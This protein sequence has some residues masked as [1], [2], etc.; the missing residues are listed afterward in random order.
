MTTIINED[1]VELEELVRAF[2]FYFGVCKNLI[3]EFNK[4]LTRS[5]TKEYRSQRNLSTFSYKTKKVALECEYGLLKDD[6]IR[7]RII[8][9]VLDAAFSNEL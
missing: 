4:N 6:L 1:I 3:V 2:D 7:D 9:G 8:A 5:S